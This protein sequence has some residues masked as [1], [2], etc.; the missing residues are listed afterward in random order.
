MT[1]TVKT[2]TYS[3]V[4]TEAITYWRARLSNQIT[5]PRSNLLKIQGKK[6]LK[7][8]Y[9]EPTPA[10]TYQHEK[11]VYFAQEYQIKV[12]FFD[13]SVLSVREVETGLVEV[14]CPLPEGFDKST[15]KA[16]V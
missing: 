16:R 8:Y 7:I 15:L 10:A 2:F 6:L 9:L 11:K 1:N 3:P 12:R 14:L 5:N 13:L 4:L